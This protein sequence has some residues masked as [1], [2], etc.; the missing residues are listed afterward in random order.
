M[1]GGIDAFS[2]KLARMDSAVVLGAV[3]GGRPKAS[4]LSSRIRVAHGR[5]LFIH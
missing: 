2:G 3:R 1:A 4:G 5:V